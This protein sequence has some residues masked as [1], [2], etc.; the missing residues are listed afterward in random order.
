MANPNSNRIDTVISPA[1]LTTITTAGST[2]QTTID[3]YMSDLTD[4]ERESLFSLAEENEAFA[5]D[6]LQQGLTLNAQMPPAMQIIITN[7]GRDTQMFDQLDELNDT[8][9]NPL[10]QRINDTRRLAA[11]EQYT[12]A[13]AVYK[14]IEAGAQLA[15]P[16]FQAA[17]DI[18]KVRF[19][20]QGRREP[21]VN[22]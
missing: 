19:E 7:M 21:G 9:V 4:E 6:A 1:D 13:L 16:G 2:I 17:Y 8:L 15:M 14:F 5:D 12:G 3:P 11:H 10:V 20:R 22:P 18:L